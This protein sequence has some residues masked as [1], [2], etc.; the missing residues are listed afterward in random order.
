MPPED[1]IRLRRRIQTVGDDAASDARQMHAHM[2]VVQTD[3]HTSIKRNAAGVFHE[4]VGNLV[5]SAEVILMIVVDVRDN[6]EGGGELQKR[7]IRFIGFGD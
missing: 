1:A 2:R 4:G 5:E 3:N 7:T 6:S